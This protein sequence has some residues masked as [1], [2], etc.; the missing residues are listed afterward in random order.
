MQ[1][2]YRRDRRSAWEAGVIAIVPPIFCRIAA[3]NFSGSKSGP[4][5]NVMRVGLYRD[6]A[7]E[8]FLMAADASDPARKAALIQMAQAWVLLA[9]QAQ[10]NRHLHL[11]SETFLT[12]PVDAC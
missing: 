10:K 6:Y 12:R 5:R 7:V 8:C 1:L 3:E 4:G 11:V 2:D 9:K